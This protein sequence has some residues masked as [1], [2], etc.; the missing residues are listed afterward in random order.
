MGSMAC[1][2]D[3]YD[4]VIIGAGVVGLTLAQAFKHVSSVLNAN[5]RNLF[6]ELRSDLYLERDVDIDAR[7]NG[8]GITIGWAKPAMEKCIPTE[9]FN[10]LDSIAVDSD[11]K[12]KD[13]GY[14]KYIN[15]TTLDN[16]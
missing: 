9:M 14:Y 10:S 15:L 8:W 2:P 1:D 6:A 13:T 3:V 7:G 11:L 5:A 12:T 4:V 16:R